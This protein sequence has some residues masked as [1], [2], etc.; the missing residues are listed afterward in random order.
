GYRGVDDAV[1][2]QVIHR[3]KSKTLTAQQRGWLRRRQAIEPAIGHTKSDHGM[4]RCWLKG[5]DGDALHAVLCAAGFNIRWLL[6]AI[7]RLGLRG[8]FLVLNVLML[9][10][11]LAV[12][13]AAGA[14]AHV[15]KLWPPSRDVAGVRRRP[16]PALM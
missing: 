5:S 11:R 6:R 7:A 2:V 4:N 14:S 13:S 12:E 10:G 8:L 16:Q 3:G 15:G 9:Y 1:S